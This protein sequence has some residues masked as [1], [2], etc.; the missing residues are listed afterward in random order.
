MARRQRFWPAALALTVLMFAQAARST[1]S[2]EE[3]KVITALIQRVEQM[4]ALQFMRNGN[5]HTAAEA[6]EH[7]QAKYRHFNKE[8][9]TAEDFIARCASRSEM[10]GKPYTVKLGD[11]KAQ[12]AS[13]FLMQELRA[14]RRQGR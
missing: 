7:M 13:G 6:A 8:I 9:V 11:G 3:H 14:V 10:T 2:P 5:P 12:P 1:P 4:E